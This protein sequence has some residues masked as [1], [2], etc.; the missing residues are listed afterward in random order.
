MAALVELYGYPDYALEIIDYGHER[1][2]EKK[3]ELDTIKKIIILNSNKKRSL[4]D[5]VI[6]RLRRFILREHVFDYPP[7]HS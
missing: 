2:Q 1:F 6:R 3:K 7:L 5:K 4:T